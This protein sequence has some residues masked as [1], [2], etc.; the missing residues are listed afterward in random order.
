MTRLTFEVSS[1]EEGDMRVTRAQAFN[2]GRSWKVTMGM[3][4]KRG[5]SKMMH[6]TIIL[7]G[8]L[9]LLNIVMCVF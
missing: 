8:G 9:S 7:Q 4:R 6:I 3:M 2:L 1:I 5:E